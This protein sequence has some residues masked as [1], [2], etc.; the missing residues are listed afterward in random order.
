MSVHTQIASLHY[1]SE[2]HCLLLAWFTSQEGDKSSE[3]YMVLPSVFSFLFC[4]GINIL[5]WSSFS[6]VCVYAYIHIC[7]Q[8]HWVLFIYPELFSQKKKKNKFSHEQIVL[9]IVILYITGR[10]C[11]GPSSNIFMHQNMANLTVVIM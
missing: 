6:P 8:Y 5:C 11:D 7:T 1:D 9:L 3:L 10:V 4:L 2:K